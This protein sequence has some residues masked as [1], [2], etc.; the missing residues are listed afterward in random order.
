MDAVEPPAMEAKL[1]KRLAGQADVRIALVVAEEDVVARLL[2]LDEV[3]LE[4]QR[5][6]LGAR[7]RRFDSHHLREHHRDPRFVRALL[8]I[9]RH[10]LLQVARLA[11]VKGFA[12]A[13]VHPVDAG[14]MRQRTDQLARVEGRRHLS[15]SGVTGCCV[16]GRRGRLGGRRGHSA[17]SG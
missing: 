8:E 9:A 4:Q 15:C 3:V 12:L 1:R 11:D 5:L 14:T 16:N 6:A 17:V 10:A 2:R 7:H 13:V